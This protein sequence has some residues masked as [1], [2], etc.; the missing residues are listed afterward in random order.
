[1]FSP[2]LYSVLKFTLSYIVT[3]GYNFKLSKEE[4]EQHMV[5]Q[6]DDMLF[7]QIRQM[8]TVNISDLLFSLTQRVAKTILLLLI[9]WLN[10]V[11]N[12]MDNNIYSVN[13]V[14]V[15]SVKACSVLWNGIFIQSWTS[16]L[17]WN[18][19]FLRRQLS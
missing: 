11:S 1:M 19:I 8:I 14:P 15:W 9:I 12:L 6:G 4:L 10:M 3:R 13:V 16:V 18:L 5:L 7:R 17:A 2:P